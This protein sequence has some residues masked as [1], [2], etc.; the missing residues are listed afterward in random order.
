[1][2][3]H[4]HIAGYKIHKLI[5]H[6]GTADVYLAQQ[7][8][9]GRDIAL[10]ILNSKQH[11]QDFSQRFI[12]EGKLIASLEHPN[13]IT[14]YDIGVTNTGLHY[15]AME[16][17]EGGDL[18]QQVNDNAI[19]AEQA[20]IILRDVASTLQFV[21]EQ[22]IIHRDIKPAN[23]LFR[24]NSSIVL[25]DFGIAK[26]INDDVKLTKTGSTVGSPAYS[27]PEQIQGMK[28]D[29]RTDIY[30][31]GITFLEILLGNNPYK[32]DIYANGYGRFNF[33]I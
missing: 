10:K 17:I 6:G 29:P 3:N 23:I 24:K 16:Y 7:E 18:E 33:G 30:S 20:L 21:H 12:K 11:D 2:S 32:T 4:P 25:T 9:L 15:I 14:I 8:S 28:L 19:T 31:L 1:M 5:A 27:S 26:L 13:V 22:G